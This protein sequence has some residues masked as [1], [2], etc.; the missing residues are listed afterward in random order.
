MLAEASADENS[1]VQNQGD[2]SPVR[3][4]E[5]EHRIEP[6]T[7]TNEQEMSPQGRYIRVSAIQ[8]KI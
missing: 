3:I 4:Q 2:S 1:D 6:V 8:K 5:I 7:N